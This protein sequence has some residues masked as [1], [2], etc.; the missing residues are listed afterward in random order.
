DKVGFIGGDRIAKPVALVKM[1]ATTPQIIFGLAL[2]VVSAAIWLVVLS[3]VPISFAY[4][5]A[6]LVYVLTAGFSKYVLH[7]HVPNLRWLGIALIIIGILVVGRTATDAGSR[8]GS[9]PGATASSR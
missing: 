7:E 8:P 9:H 6:G 4:P 3:R 2:F 5:F 1:I